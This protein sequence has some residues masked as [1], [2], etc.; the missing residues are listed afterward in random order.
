MGFQTGSVP[1]LKAMAQLGLRCISA[2]R[3]GIL[4]QGFVTSWALWELKGTDAAAY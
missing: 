3:A 2:L 1:A 4:S